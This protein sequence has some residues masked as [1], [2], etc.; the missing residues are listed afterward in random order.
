MFVISS[1][2]E[3]V[4]KATVPQKAPIHIKDVDKMIENANAHQ[5]SKPSR[6]D[7]ARMMNSLVMST[8]TQ[9]AIEYVSRPAG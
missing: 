3:E 1:Q 5:G 6:Q 8:H 2:L 4:G 7:D 9:S